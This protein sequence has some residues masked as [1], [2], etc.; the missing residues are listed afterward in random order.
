MANDLFTFTLTRSQLQAA[1]SAGLLNVTDL[2]EQS[3]RICGNSGL[4]DEELVKLYVLIS[5]AS[6]EL[7]GLKVNLKYIVEKLE[8]NE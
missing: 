8:R 1:V 4:S 6:E 3:D 2:L 5:E 7:L